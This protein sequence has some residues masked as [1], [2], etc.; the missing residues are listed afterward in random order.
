ML[1]YICNQERKVLHDYLNAHKGGVQCSSS[2]GGLLG[3]SASVSG[4]AYIME[5]KGVA[6]EVFGGSSMDFASESGF[7]TDDGALKLWN[8]AIEVYNWKVNGV[9]G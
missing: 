6:E 8:K 3:W 2:T 5:T 9:A 7:E 1:H 4:L